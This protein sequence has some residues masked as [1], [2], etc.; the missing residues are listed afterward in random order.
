MRWR[1]S[2]S[3]ILLLATHPVEREHGEWVQSSAPSRKVQPEAGGAE[4]ARAYLTTG[5]CVRLRAADAL[6]GIVVGEVH[7]GKPVS[8]RRFTLRIGQAVCVDDIGPPG[9]GLRERGAGVGRDARFNPRAEIV[10]RRLAFAGR[11]RCEERDLVSV[12]AQQGQHGPQVG[13]DTAN[14]RP[15]C[16]GNEDAHQAV[17]RTL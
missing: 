17:A 2:A 3:R 4:R 15:V 12:P 5:E 14:D 9:F 1:W 16:G 8:E 11:V 6:P 13:L 7:G 10:E